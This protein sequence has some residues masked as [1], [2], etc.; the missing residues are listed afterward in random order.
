MYPNIAFMRC[1]LY[2][3][4]IALLYGW[5]EGRSKST[6]VIMHQY[7]TAGERKMS[8]SPLG[9]HLNQIKRI[10]VTLPAIKQNIHRQ[11]YMKIPKLTL[12]HNSIL[13]KSANA[14]L[15]FKYCVMHN[16]RSFTDVVTRKH[17]KA[18]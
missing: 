18:I 2:S 16:S 3:D 6:F 7:A 8:E 12:K 5:S 10:A 17:M 15:M 4:P 1:R 11:D 13:K 14:I 9:Q